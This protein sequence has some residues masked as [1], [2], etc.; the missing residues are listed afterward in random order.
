[1][2]KEEYKD[3]E[4]NKNMYRKLKRTYLKLFSSKKE[5]RKKEKEEKKLSLFS[6]L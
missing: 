6:Y 4:M 2:K 1:M 3:E 5:K